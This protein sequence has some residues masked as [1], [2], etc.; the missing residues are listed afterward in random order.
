MRR[1][2]R[3]GMIK[4]D[5]ILSAAAR[6]LRSRHHLLRTNAVT[7]LWIFPHVV[8]GQREG[9]GSL[10][11]RQ[12]AQKN[13]A[14]FTW[15]AALRLPANQIVVGLADSQHSYPAFVIVFVRLWR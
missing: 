14:A 1:M 5:N 13:S 2:I 11:I 9:D 8:T 3:M 15:V 6:Q 7:R 12:P 4:T 10:P